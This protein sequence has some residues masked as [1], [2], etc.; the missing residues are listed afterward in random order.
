MG[1][2]NGVA[3]MLGQGGVRVGPPDE[4]AKIA[5]LAREFEAMMTRRILEQ[6]RESMLGGEEAGLGAATMTSTFDVELSNLLASGRGVGLA[7]AL[8]SALERQTV[9][10]VEHASAAVGGEYARVT[11]PPAAVPP[12]AREG[13]P[14][15]APLPLPARITS[16][17]GLRE[18]PF[19]AGQRFHHGVD[20]AAAYGREVPAVAD[21]RV[22]FAGARGSYGNM[23]E[24]EHADGT[25]S[26]YAHLAAVTVREGEAVG[27]GRPIGTVGATGR[28][29]G[30]HLHFE[31]LQHGKPVDPEL[32]AA[33]F[34]TALKNGATVAD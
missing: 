2:V 5:E 34:G 3:R 14:P 9:H 31:L 23:V 27:A 6:M 13:A 18:D 19:G 33:R 22:A 16:R 28:S 25:R 17:F 10:A 29:T 20:I 1:D 12:S 30:P 8:R 15:A 24:I 21:G 11:L 7:G 26:R 32:A 4:R